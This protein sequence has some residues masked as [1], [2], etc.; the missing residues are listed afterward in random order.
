MKLKKLSTRWICSGVIALALMLTTT[1][2]GQGVT[3]S[4]LTGFVTDKAGKPIEG[5][6]VTVVLDASGGRYVATTGSTG[7][8]NLSGLIT[9]GPYTIT[10]TAPNLPPAEKKDVYTSLGS[11]GSVDLEMSSDV[12]QLEAYKVNES[13]DNSTFGAQAMG[14]GSSY[15][16]KQILT[17]S[18]IRRD[19]QDF[20]NLDPRAVVMQGAPSDPAYTFS[21]AGQ[22]PRE[23]ALLVDGVSAADNFGL[24]S[25]GY[26]GLRNPVPLEWIAAATLQINPF[27]VAYSGFLGG[28][29]DVSLKSGTNEF[30][31]SAYVVYT[32][33]NMR[34]SDPVVGLLGPHE[35]TQQHTT[36]ATLGGP[37]IPNKL[38]FFVGYEA[39]RQI[40]A[41]PAQVFNP[42]SN[43]TGQ[44]EV[45]EI[46]A[47]LKAG[48]T[49]GGKTYTYDPGSLGAISHTWEQN[50][51]G[52]I[53]WNISDYQKFSFTFRHTKG[54]APVFYNYTF[55]NETSFETS[56]Y[57][58]NRSDQS[59]TAQLNSDWSKYVSNLQTE[60][61]ATYKRYNGTASLNGPD[62]PALTI[63][64]ITGFSASTN[65]TI[66]TGELFT[67]TYAAYQDNN[68][69]TWEQEE[70]AYADYSLG[71]HTFKFG[72]QADRTAYT[73]TFIPNA[74]GS[75]NFTTVANFLAKVA[76]TSTVESPAAGYTLAS[77]V[78]H[79]YLLDVAPLLQDTWKPN[80]QWT[81]VGGLRMDYPYEP[82]NPVFSQV[83][84]NAYGFSNAS[85]MNGNYVVSPR[86]GFNYSLPTALPTQIRG[87]AG[88]FLG[89]NPVVWV[90]NSFNNAGQ[91][92]VTTNGV[93][94][95]AAPS[96]DYT[97]PNFKWPSTWKENLAIDKTLPLWG[98][99]A[100]AEVDF[101]QVNKD[102]FYQ[103]TNPYALP[104]SGPLTLPDG[105]LRFA[106]LITPGTSGSIGS[107]V[108][109]NA[110]A[111]Y[112]STVSS[113][114]TLLYQNHATGAVYDL[115]N[116]TKGATQEYTVELQKPMK[117]NWAFSLA[118]T[119][120]HA[121]QVDP[122]TSSVASSGFNSQPFVN[123]NQNVAYN[124]NYS[125]PN[126]YVATLTR[127]FNF[128]KQRNSTTSLSLQYISQSGAAYSY[129]FKGDAD[130]SGITGE[131]LFYVPTGPSDPKVTWLSASEEN[132]F[133]T[134]LAHTPSLSKYA[135]QVAPRN[136][137]YENEQE[138]LNIH[139][140]QQVP[141]YKNIRTVLYIDCFNFANFLD[142]NW[143][144]VDNFNNA[145]VTQTVAGTGFNPKTNQYI[146]TFNPSTLGTP[147]IYSDVSRWQVQV[148]AR[149]EF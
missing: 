93:A 82:Q 71:N 47:A 13:A 57:N 101:T 21:V 81:L 143:G 20:Q 87:G 75:Y 86:F 112:Y 35:P 90:E 134:W 80:A 128:F 130:G 104:T 116:T 3:T 31:G 19:L 64:A 98:L 7:R 70:H 41:A 137:A 132:N 136:S 92:N 125:V 147:T 69:Y 119:Y 62:L 43:A 36:G 14:T 103:E 34:G 61:E 8:Y 109:P 133:F 88:L 65:T 95:A 66:A 115:T 79:Y 29:T 44:Q 24:N 48:Y 111:G 113:S 96:F 49:I 94:S 127:Q 54:D 56:W 139:L 114:P 6:T 129:V 51:V 55:A 85:T 46:V 102:V 59:Y 73:D 78:S 15:S 99:V 91:L 89:Q 122:F 30:H 142:K 146:Y 16:S 28:V 141:L 37:I 67:G 100:T 110:P 140:E 2:F 26:A 25:N 145:F 4:G 40:A 83:F 118:Y 117:N 27:D 126:K 97:D 53:D 18:S 42:L 12:V 63:N 52:K 5:A 11:T 32:G 149:L 9:G 144:I 74:I 131:S 138:T 39:F 121:T 17:V 107:F 120:T 1:M 22:N 72:V 68:I 135:G 148:G 108:Q 33:T 84:Q 38:F 124:S 77:D 123:P 23:N 50:F 105:R 76:S 60:I 10:A 58:S 106:G 45:S